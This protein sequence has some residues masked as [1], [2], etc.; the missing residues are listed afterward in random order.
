[1]LYR[2]DD[3]GSNDDDDDKHNSEM[4]VIV[5]ARQCQFATLQDAFTKTVL[6]NVN[7]LQH[8]MSYCCSA[9]C[10][11]MQP[12]SSQSRSWKALSAQDSDNTAN[13][14]QATPTAGAALVFSRPLCLA[15]GCLYHIG[16]YEES[17]RSEG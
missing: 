5:M 12:L 9:S 8:N 14:T 13:K 15:V 1:M 2:D 11:T 17:G 4:M 10:S 3:D 16:W 7:V 6:Q